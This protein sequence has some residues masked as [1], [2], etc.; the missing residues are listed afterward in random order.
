MK[1]TILSVKQSELLENLIVNHGQIVTSGQIISQAE[2]N[3]DYKQAKNLI[4]KLVKNGWLMRIKRGLYAISDLSTRGFLTLSPYVVANLLVPDSYVSFESALQQYGMFDQLTDKTISVSLKMYK[5]VK[6]NSTEYSFVKTK[7]DYF[8]G[9]QEVNV[10]NNNVRV[11]TPEKALID[12]VNFHKSQYAIDLVIEK[13]QE[14][15]YDLDVDRLNDYLSRLSLTTVKIF[16]LI[17][18]LIGINSDKLYELV[19]TKH[20]THWMLPED[21][22]FNAKWRLYYQAYF[23][24]YQSV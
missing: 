11:A 20:G 12:M 6:L 21:S 2:G 23:D 4:T 5:A 10:D 3:W 17:F 24:K 14:H 1:Q 16:G 13:L 22:K 9:W 8:F 18:D 7:P 15:K 19:K